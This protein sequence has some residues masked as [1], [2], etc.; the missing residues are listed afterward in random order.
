MLHSFQKKNSLIVPLALF[1]R[2]NKK[3]AGEKLA[4]LFGEYLDELFASEE[5]L[6]AHEKFCNKLVTKILTSKIVADFNLGKKSKQEF[7]SEAL[8]FLN[9]PNNKAMDFEFA[10]NSLLELDK[11][12]LDVLNYLIKLTEEN[13]S[14]YFIG[15]TNELHAEKILEIF[16][17]HSSEKLAFLDSLPNPAAALPITISKTSEIKPDNRLLAVPVGS[18]YFCLSYI[19]KTLI[20]QPKDLLTKLFTFFKST[21]GLLTQLHAYLNTQG[22]TKEDILLINPYK[23]ANTITNKLAQEVIS[24]D[25]FYN[26]LRHSASAMMSPSALLSRANRL[27]RSLEPIPR[28]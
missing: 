5:E 15:N 16:A 8:S 1:I 12:A 25:D 21:S 17:F 4:N 22:K 20:E 3:K 18:V 2:F 24:K 19:Y 9:L 27:P 28:P 14:I 23:N 7:I 26:V 6:Q 11:E 13:K 10:W